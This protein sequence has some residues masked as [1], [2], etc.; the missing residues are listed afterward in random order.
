MIKAVFFDLFDTLI[1]YYPTREEMQ[2]D[3]CNLFSI[4]NVDITAI[5]RGYYSADKFFYKENDIYPLQNR[6]EK[7]KMKFFLAYEKTLLQT[8]GIIVSDDLLV[9]MLKKLQK[10]EKKLVLFDDV[11]PIF[12]L[13]KKKNISLG[14]ISNAR[15][16]S[17][18]L[19]GLGLTDYLDILATSDINEKGKPHPEIFQY[20]LNSAL[21]KAEEALH[22]GDQYEVDIVGA[23]GVGIKALLLDRNN[24]LTDLKDC[25]K[26]NSLSQIID[27]L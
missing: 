25:P 10:M 2:L 22:V 26:I 6:T 3:V 13:L 4:K 14:L 8:A 9:L 11:I 23:R 19:Q 5:R 15:Q 21:V 12:K 7:E 1:H 24:I 17:V 20:A 27:F 18:P 16:D